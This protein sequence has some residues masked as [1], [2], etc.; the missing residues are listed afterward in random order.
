MARPSGRFDVAAFPTA[1]RGLL[2]PTVADL[3]RDEPD[4]RVQPHELEPAAA[5]D[6]LRAGRVRAAVV[7]EWGAAA[8]LADGSLITFPLGVDLID[9]VLPRAHPMANRPS[10]ELVDLVD[11]S[12]A[13]TPE[14][15][16]SY[17]DW[18]ISHENVLALKPRMIYEA[19]EFS[20]LIGY[21]EHNL[22]VAAIPRLGRGPLPS[23]T[24]AVPL[25]DPSARR[26]VSVA[27]RATSRDSATV[28]CV[29]DALRVRAAG[30]LS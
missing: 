10:L 14:G 27:V 18:F 26:T 30:I 6:R 24:V 11:Q 12:W 16:R 9:I 17:R 29:V 15:E 25:R 5:L 23:A 13:L 4:L 7:K 21:V 3:V 22:A 8:A 20:S 28:G 1:M 2:I 19:A